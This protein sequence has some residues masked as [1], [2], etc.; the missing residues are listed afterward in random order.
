MSKT[1]TIRIADNIY[2]LFKLA[3]DGEHRSISNFI[4]YASLNYLTNELHVSDDEMNEILSN[5]E[6]VKSIKNGLMD[7]EKGN[8]TIIE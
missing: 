3:A 7:V 6:M 1:I 2:D 5:N 8:Y 4:E